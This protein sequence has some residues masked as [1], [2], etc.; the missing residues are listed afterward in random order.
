[1]FK[2][3]EQHMASIATLAWSGQSAVHT[4]RVL[5]LPIALVK[6]YRASPDCLAR[7]IRISAYYAETA[8]AEQGDAS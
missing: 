5:A 7:L 4:A 6:A 2:L 1:M 8:K 3:T